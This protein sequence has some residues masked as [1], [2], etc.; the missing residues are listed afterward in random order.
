MKNKAFLFSIVT[1]FTLILSACADQPEEKKT[2]SNEEHADHGEHS[3][4]G[5]I[6]EET[7]GLSSLPSFLSDKPED[8]QMIYS[9]AAKN[10]ELLEN[11][12][13][14]C[15]CGESA[16]HKNNYDCFVNENKENGAIV[17]DDHGTK[18]GVCL[19]IAAQSVLQLEEGKS[20]K[21]IRSEFDE[22][23]KEGYAKPTPTPEV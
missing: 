10:R 17:W 6:R 2:A 7:E 14:Y 15:G 9:A 5:D 8:M 21:E 3:A 20:I 12:P 19:E 11:I 22:K 1:S 23:Y 16:N 4:S 18:C 13:C